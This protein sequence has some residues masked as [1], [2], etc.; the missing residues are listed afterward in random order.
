MMT[1]HAPRPVLQNASRH[2]ARW[3]A[4]VSFA[5]VACFVGANLFAQR[6]TLAIDGNAMALV[7]SIAPRIDHLTTMR[8]AVSRMDRA[9]RDAVA[10]RSLAPEAE[11]TVEREQAL[12]AEEVA[13]LEGA[14]RLRPAVEAFERHARRTLALARDGELTAPRE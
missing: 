6:Q 7:D 8:G 13:L 2:P 4:A 10:A 9:V 14:P 11:A 3:L 12:I 1:P 5:V